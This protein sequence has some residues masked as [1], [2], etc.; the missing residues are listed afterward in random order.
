METPRT[1]RPMN[2]S[3]YLVTRLSDAGIGHAF[4]VPG[5][6]TLDFLD[7]LLDSP[8]RWVGTCNELNAGYAADGYARLRGAGLAVVTYAV[9]GFSVLNAVAGAYAENVPLLVVSGAPSGRV[10]AAG[11]LVHHLVGDFL[12]Q[13]DVF[14]RFTAATAFLSDAATAPAEID[15]VLSAA[16]SA[17]LPGYI[18][19]PMDLART[20]CAAPGP[21]PSFVPPASDPAA[22]AEA[23]AE[24]VER[25][26]RAKSPVVLV[27]VEALRF[28]LAPAV[29]ALVERIELPFA[30]T[31]SSKA[32]LPELHPQYVGLYQGVL[33]RP[34]VRRQVEESDCVLALGVKMT[35]WDTGMFTM[36][37]DPSKMIRA[38]VGDVAIR[39]HTY[40]TVRLGDLVGA[41]SATLTPRRYEESHP[42]QA[43]RPPVPVVPRAEAV[44]TAESFFRRLATFL[45]DSMTVVSDVSDVLCGASDLHVQEA[46]RFLCQAYYCSIGWSVPAALGAA[47]AR[48]E[49]RPVV[50][51]GDGAFQMTAQEVSTLM[52]EKTRA[53]V[54]VLD[55]DGYLIERLLHEDAAYNDVQRWRYAALPAVFGDGAVSF[56]VTTEGELEAALDA[57]RGETEKVVFVHLAL[58][59]RE[60]SAGLARLCAAYREKLAGRRG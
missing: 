53:V 37:I 45:D 16:L 28:G 50:L 17:R 33:S 2:V 5:D 8:I 23:V 3:R 32:A 9:G 7:H 18:E 27:G 35:D 11:A 60:P 19:I 42:R 59:G 43:V 58:S 22:L 47:L 56:R 41:L 26:D 15:R 48:P 49:R 31:T 51:V 20:P 57:A 44:L 10:R 1:D 30:T 12:L 14:R 29:L 55:N 36:G 52:R 25:I 46:D 39:S 38:G 54:F 4:G 24:A 40:P 6:Y 21:L 13:A 34:E